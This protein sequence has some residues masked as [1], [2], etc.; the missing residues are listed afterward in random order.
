MARVLSKSKLLAYRQC[1]KRAWLEVHR[2]ELREDSAGAQA[3]FDAGHRVGDIARTLYDPKGRGALL[4]PYA[5]GFDVAFKRTGELLDGNAPIFEAGF[6]ITSTLSF[7][8]VLLPVRKAGIRAWR[9]VE[10]KSSTSVKDYHHDDAAIQAYIARKS[11]LE[12]SAVAIACIDNTWKY[13]GKLDYS[14]LLYETDVTGP[15]FDRAS[16]VESWINGAQAVVARTKEPTNPIGAH[17]TQPYACGFSD[18][19][20]GL[21]PEARHPIE[22]LPGRWSKALATHVESKGTTEL[23]DLPDELLSD[24][25]LRVKSVALSGK[26]WFDRKGAA[27]VLAE[28]ALPAYF[29]D[30]E[31]I[32]FAVPIWKG[33][34][35]Y[36]QIPFQFSSHRLSQTGRIKHR[37]FLDLSGRDPSRAFTEALV[38][39][40]GTKG[41]V[42]VY[43]A[44]FEKARIRELASRYKLF[45]DSLL[46][47]EARI[48]DLLPVARQHYYHPSQQ[49]SWS[50]KAVL[51][52]LCPDLD[53]QALDGVQDG[54]MAM[55]A[56]LEAIAPD[57]SP[58]RRE[59][60]RR[61][62]LAY[63]QLDTFALIRLW[64]KFSGNPVEVA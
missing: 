64:S 4:D 2:P 25:Q 8:D 19:C 9:M 10:V 37:E 51:P 28:H 56:Y 35:P 43:N 58:S 21:L 6:R 59:E 60:I 23:Q 11:G 24:R 14:G 40:C 48:V 63:C 1:P 29:L 26:P 39:A 55:D 38:S 32:Q 33:T 18:Y 49:G 47:I 20:R 7:A 15:A 61:Q 57:T 31:T 12:L 27:G 42:F 53:Y 50:I 13:P 44:G 45:S 17:C 52:A 46:A 41:P 62:L 54:G 22:Q 36:Q 5:E 16:E 34:R 30:F 3:R